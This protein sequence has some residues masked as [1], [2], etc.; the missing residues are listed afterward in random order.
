M[1][2]R[3]RYPVT[4]QGRLVAV[5]LMRGIALLSV[6]TAGIAAWFVRQSSVATEAS[7]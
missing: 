2:Y 5:V 4:T 1:G 6:L 7:R 3:D